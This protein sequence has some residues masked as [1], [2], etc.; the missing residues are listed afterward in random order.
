MTGKDLL[1][2]LRRTGTGPFYLRAFH[3][4]LLARLDEAPSKRTEPDWDLAKKAVCEREKID[5][6]GLEPS[7]FWRLV[8]EEVNRQKSYHDG[9][10]LRFKLALAEEAAARLT[11]RDLLEAVK[12]LCKASPEGDIYSVTLGKAADL[13][14]AGD[15]PEKMAVAMKKHLGSPPPTSAEARDEKLAATMAREAV[16]AAARL[17]ESH[18]EK[19]AAA[20]AKGAGRPERPAGAEPADRLGGKV[21]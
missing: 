5:E 9:A 1:D 10:D 21:K 3:D 12:A 14:E 2:G 18:Q 15:D 13:V 7:L 20:Q 19:Q 4:V 6:K 8:F 17:Q 16:A 11:A